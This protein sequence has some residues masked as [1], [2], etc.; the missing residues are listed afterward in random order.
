MA[1]Y[2]RRAPVRRVQRAG[3]NYQPRIHRGVEAFVARKRRDFRAC[4]DWQALDIEKAVAKLPVHPPFFARLRRSQQICVTIGAHMR[5]FA[6]YNDMGTGKSLI[7]MALAAYF[8]EAEGAKRFLVLVPNRVNLRGWLDQIN[9]H[10]PEIKAVALPSNVPAKLA[11]LQDSDALLFIETYAGFARLC[12]QKGRSRKRVPAPDMVQH[13]VGLL[14]GLILDESSAVGHHNSLQTE[15]ISD[16]VAHKDASKLCVFLLSGTPFGRDP[17][18]LWS[19]MKLLDGGYT[20]GETL[21]LFRATFFT[22][23]QN[24]FGGWEHEF[25][26][27]TTPLLHR[28]IAHRSI[29]FA[30]DQADLPAVTP[31]IIRL[32]LA[33]DAAQLYEAAAEQLRKSRGHYDLCKNAFMRMRQISS[34]FINMKDP[35]TGARERLEFKDNPKLEWIRSQI[36][37][38]DGQIIIFHDFIYS[39]ELLKRT[40]DEMK[41]GN[42][43][44]NGQVSGGAVNKAYD[45]FTQGRAQVLLLNSQAGAFGVNLQMARYGIY[46]ESP[47]PVITR[48]QTELRF[49]RPG[50]EHQHV[51]K[52]DLVVNNT[53][54]EAILDFHAQ[55][56]SLFKAILDGSFKI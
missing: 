47:V 27:K 50:S 4:L 22:T 41:I 51:V 20:L 13:M 46:F 39:G 35:D 29:R 2:N 30:L 19:Q 53:V 33:T 26:K 21:T 5:R 40:L 32:D 18:L 44:I 28:H 38:M 17:H 6:F 16:I 24:Y 11:T 12:S 31:I 45:D 56:S 10:A 42:V 43:I 49:V 52:V 3:M 23:K 48:K 8:A 14:D 9:K 54:D 1:Q 37:S 34:G 7:G 55:G 36:E 25:Q 15:I